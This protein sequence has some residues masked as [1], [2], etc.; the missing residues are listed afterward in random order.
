MTAKK[1]NLD[2]DEKPLLSSNQAAIPPSQQQN[3]DFDIKMDEEAEWILY[4]PELDLA[5]EEAVLLRALR[6]FNA[7]DRPN[8]SNLRGVSSSTSSGNSSTSWRVYV[9]NLPVLTRSPCAEALS[10]CSSTVTSSSSSSSLS[11]YSRRV[12]FAEKLVT[13]VRL[14]PKT[15]P[16]EQGALFYTVDEI[17][18]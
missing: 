1:K 11:S 2:D 9:E 13:E 4:S 3:E 10:L 5:V 6:T 17:H 12:R 8:N 15:P 14:R 18:R 7:Q 16:D